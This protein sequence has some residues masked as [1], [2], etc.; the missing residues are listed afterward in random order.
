M[1]VLSSL[2]K[3]IALALLSGSLAHAAPAERIVS[4]GGSVTEIVY[5]LGEGHR[6]VARDS[7]S[8]YPAEAEALP[9]VGYARALSPEGVLSVAPDMI[10]AS[11]GAGPLETLEVLKQANVAYAEVPELYSPEGVI[12]KIETVAAALG[13]EE[14]AATL[15]ADI[16][17]RLVAAQA[18]AKVQAGDSPVRVLFILSTQGGRIMAGGR[19]TA[20][21][22]IIRMAGGINAVDSF[23]GYKPMTDEAVSA[24]APDVIL[25]M[26]RGGD[27]GVA[28][29]QL[30]SLPALIPTP[31]AQNGRLV[32]MDGLSLLGF[33]PRTADT[34]ETLS[35]AFY[36]G[37]GE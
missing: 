9:N 3:G 6:L 25:A 5:A 24:T 23:E 11:S 34:I 15:I 14:K 18:H 8:S 22:G 13:A 16:K 19:G 7:T 27:H 37:H 30:A 33:G 21:D 28:L 29:E 12:R 10:I 32:R 26:D 1:G 20:A 2:S 17:P 4:V 35:R 31:A 36:E